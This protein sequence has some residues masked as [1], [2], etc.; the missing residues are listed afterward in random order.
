MVTK[1][2]RWLTTFIITDKTM[3]NE[4]NKKDKTTRLLLNLALLKTS[5][6]SV[7]ELA[8]TCS[9][10][11]FVTPGAPLYNNVFNHAQSICLEKQ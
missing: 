2:P 10:Y 11:T 6:I 9:P 5:I 3:R 1:K 4:N 7:R 8:V